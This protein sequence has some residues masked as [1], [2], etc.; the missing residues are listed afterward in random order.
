[1]VQARVASPPIKAPAWPT[2]MHRP[3]SRKKIR[4]ILNRNRA[5]REAGPW[6]S[7][8]VAFGLSIDL[9]IGRNP[10]SAVGT[11]CGEGLD[12]EQSE[13]DENADA[14]D[15]DAVVL[16][17]RDERLHRVNLGDAAGHVD[18]CTRGW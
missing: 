6:V 9:V 16:Q 3:A 8:S 10:L 15:G 2:T 13:G 17:Q 12:G 18:R 11:W 1:M 4:L 14:E 7:R 5:S